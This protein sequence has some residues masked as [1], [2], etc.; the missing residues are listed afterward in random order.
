MKKKY[1]WLLLAGSILLAGCTNEAANLQ[2]KVDSV[3]SEKEELVVSLNSIQEQEANVQ[4]NFDDSLSADG[5]L[6]SFQD[7][8]AVVFENIKTRE[9]EVGNAK[10]ILKKIQADQEELTGFEEETLPLDLLHEFSSTVGEIDRLVEDYLSAYENQLNQEKEI[11]QSLGGEEADFNTL[12]EGVDTL[13]ET[14]SSNLEKIRPLTDLFPNFD[15]QA[16]KLSA[17]LDEAKNK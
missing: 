3:V 6:K 13:N 12:Y 5:E 7:G 8:T 15:E 10:D 14:S 17:A 11:F 9:E 1:R 2:K 16:G 4:K